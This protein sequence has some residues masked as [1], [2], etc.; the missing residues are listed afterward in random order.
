MPKRWSTK[1]L[2]VIQRPSDTTSGIG[3]FE[4]TDDYS[5]FHFGKM[6]DR[7]RDK[8]EAIARMAAFNF[9]LFH[10]AS[11]PTHFRGFLRPRAIE[12]T[13]LRVLD[14]ASAPIGRGERNYLIPLQ[15]VFRNSLPAGSSVFRRLKRGTARLAQF[16][17]STMPTL[18]T[19]FD[20]PLIEFMTKL[21]EIDRFVDEAEAC[22]IA[23]LTDR[24]LV[25]IKQLTVAVSEV[26]SRH[27]A[28]LGLQH[29]DGKLEFGVDDRGEVMLVDVAGTPDENRLL[30]QGIDVTKQIM[31]DYYAPT[32]FELRIQQWATTGRPRE[33]WEA[34]PPLPPE[35]LACVSD[36]YRSVCERWTGARLWGA[37]PLEDLVATVATLRA[38]W[39]PT[40][41]PSST[42]PSRSPDAQPA[43]H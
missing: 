21:E 6:P 27:S 41:A 28:S 34:P 14:P 35:L 5:V 7:V 29:A 13:L 9:P 30:F 11:I 8:G 18:G 2:H 16:G 15:V 23:A 36:V 25:T 12:F 43:G 32:D 42:I 1:N 26:I 10:G 4:F 40:T 17:W 22:R 20:S 37:P 3:V 31:R 39:A 33:E 19:V 38:R 24:Q